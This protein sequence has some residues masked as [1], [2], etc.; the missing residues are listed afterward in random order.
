M[1]QEYNTSE[2]ASNSFQFCELTS[3]KVSGDAGL[4]YMLLCEFFCL[5]L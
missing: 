5:S 2:H 3:D 1:V 4:L